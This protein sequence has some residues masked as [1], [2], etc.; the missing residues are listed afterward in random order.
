MKLRKPLLPGL[1]ILLG[2]FLLA[3]IQS[4]A[5]AGHI[6]VQMIPPA[7][8]ITLGTPFVLKIKITNDSTQNFSFNKVAIGYLLPDLTAKGPYQVDVA[9]KT[10]SPGGYVTLSINFQIS[11]NAAIQPGSM[12]PISAAVYYNYLGSGW[13]E[14]GAGGILVKING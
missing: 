9:N 5:W 3:G 11:N 14:S 6:K 2:V 1:A 12:V 13:R 10:L 7:A 8:G 4:P